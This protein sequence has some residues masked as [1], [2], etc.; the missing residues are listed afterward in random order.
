MRDD[1]NS[2]LFY[3]REI[4]NLKSE[5]MEVGAKKEFLEGKLRE[6]G[7]RNSEGA[8]QRIEEL[9]QE[10]ENIEYEIEEIMSTLHREAT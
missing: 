1:K 4:E 6:K 2:I 8:A 3:Q 5:L 10:N 9:K 7:F